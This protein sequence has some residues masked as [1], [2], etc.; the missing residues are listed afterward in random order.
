MVVETGHP[1]DWQPSGLEG[2]EQQQQPGEKRRGGDP[3]VGQQGQQ[4]VGPRVLVRGGM[5]ADWQCNDPRDDKGHDVQQQRIEQAGPHQPQDRYL[6]GEGIPK[7]PP[8]NVRQP[9]QVLHMQRLVQAE[10]GA[11]AVDRLL[12]DD[13]VQADV[14]QKVARGELDDHKRHHRNPEEHRDQLEDAPGNVADHSCRW[15]GSGQDYGRVVVLWY[16][17]S[18]SP[19]MPCRPSLTFPSVLRTA[20]CVLGLVKNSIGT[21]VATISCQRKYSCF[22]RS[23]LISAVAR[24]KRR[25]ISTSHSV[26]ALSCFGHH[27]CSEPE[28]SQTLRPVTGSMPPVRPMITA[29]HLNVPVSLPTSVLN[30][31]GANVTR[32]PSLVKSWRT[33]F[34]IASRSVLPALVEMVNSTTFPWLSCR[35]PS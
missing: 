7:I 14:G 9:S 25:S 24:S 30:A 20:G 11:H 23:W 2:N 4:V 1:S 26:T 12:R 21:S 18:S 5:D 3:D 22:R 27:M 17:V 32:M 31:S 35:R 29:S 19:G 6:I 34:P 16:S 28:L 15:G 10:V 13:G 33:M 8:Y